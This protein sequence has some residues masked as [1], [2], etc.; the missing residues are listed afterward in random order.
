MTVNELKDPESTKE[1]LSRIIKNRK[2]SSLPLNLTSSRSHVF[3]RLTIAIK[4]VSPKQEEK[5]ISVPILFADLAGISR[6][7][8]KEELPS[9]LLKEN[10]CINKS[11]FFLNRILGLY[12]SPEATKINGKQVEFYRES[13]LTM[14]IYEYLVDLNVN[15][16]LIFH[17][18]G[19]N[20]LNDFK[21]TQTLL[22][23]IGIF[24]EKQEK[25]TVSEVDPIKNEVKKSL[26]KSEKNL[27]SL[28][29]NMKNLLEDG[30][31]EYL[32]KY[33]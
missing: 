9:L 22:E 20:Q 17:I 4:Y 21:E 18:N 13:K 10:C 23:D 2:I 29:D 15:K 24:A 32:N 5:Y 7:N 11:I 8:K 33:M 1:I 3:F 6:Y 27:N 30:Q 25:K 12:L 31:G 14:I 16:S 26:R 19:K 28:M